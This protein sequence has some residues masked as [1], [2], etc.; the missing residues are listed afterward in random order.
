MGPARTETVV[1]IGVDAE[2]AVPDHD[3]GPGIEFRGDPHGIGPL[4]LE[5]QDPPSSACIPG[6]ENAKP[7]QVAVSIQQSPGQAAVQ[8]LFVIG[9]PI[10]PQGAQVFDCRPGGDDARIIEDPRF[11]TF[12][13]L[14]ESVG[15]VG[16]ITHRASP[17]DGRFQDFVSTLPFS[18]SPPQQVLFPVKDADPPGSAHLVQ[19][20]GE[21]IHVQTL[22]ID[23][24]AGHRLGAVEQHAGPVAMG[25]RDNLCGRKGRAGDIRGPGQ[26]DQPHRSPLQLLLHRRKVELIIAVNRDRL[27]PDQALLLQAKPGKQV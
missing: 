3:I 5:S 25:Q 21:K 7:P 18:D 6:S 16:R 19:G 23:G 8:P 24:L 2:G 20:K 13:R 14:Q 22:N 9:N 10:H 11:I 4:H 27:H 1:E 15:I 26:A 17:Q 12:R